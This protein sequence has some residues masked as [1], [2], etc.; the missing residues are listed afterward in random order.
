MDLQI[1]VYLGFLSKESGTG[2]GAK[3]FKGGPLGELVQWSDLI[4][5]LF[6]LGHNVVVHSEWKPFAKLVSANRRRLT[7]HV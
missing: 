4:V 7:A 6:A 3:A 5:A 1:V 2:F